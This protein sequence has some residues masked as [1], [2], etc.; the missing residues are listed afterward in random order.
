VPVRAYVESHKLI[1]KTYMMQASYPVFDRVVPG[2]Q[3]ANSRTGH[4]SDLQRP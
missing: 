2:P 1:E 3:C 4:D